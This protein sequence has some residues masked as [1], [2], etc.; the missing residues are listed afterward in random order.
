[1][2][3]SCVQRHAAL[4]LLCA[5]GLFMRFAVAQDP[6][7]TTA[8]ASQE[9]HAPTIRVT[10][11]IVVLDVTVMDKQ[12]HLVTRPLDRDDFTVLEDGVPQTIR[13]F[14][15]PTEHRM[16][17]TDV[18]I[19]HSAADLKKIGDAPVDVLV[20][21]E[22]N[23]RFEDMSFARQQM[24]KYLQTQ[25]SVLRQPTLLLIAA[26]THFVQVHDYTQDRD[27]LINVIEK[28]MPEF[29]WRMENGAAG[30]GAAERMAQ[31]MAALIQIAQATTGT[32]GRKNII[33][34]G[35]GFPSANLVGLPAD[36][37][38]VIEA[39]F[40]RVTAELLAAH[41]TVYTISPALRASYTV[42]VFGPEDMGYP[43]TLTGEDPFGTG[44]VDFIN[45]APFTGGYAFAGRNDINNLIAEA[46]GNG[47]YYYTLSYAPAN[48]SDDPLKFRKITIRMKDPSLRAI[49]R[50]GY[51]QLTDKDLNPVT[52]TETTSLKQA[53][54]NLQLDMSQALTSVITYNGLDVT[55]QKG[56]DGTYRVHVAE[57]GLGWSSPAQD[58]K[59]INEAT[60]A[61]AWFDSKGKMLGHVAR[62]ETCPRR[63]P[64]AG[65]D[66]SLPITLP[67]HTARLRLMVR[68]ARSAN[69]GT[70]DITK[71]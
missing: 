57:K 14:E 67:L 69:I 68:D 64:D 58:G 39:A 46:I 10:S 29:P 70:V 15:P 38:D 66:Y 55:A 62:E 17:Q 28:H 60:I 30:P 36:E 12:R 47:Q 50:N 51:Y 45:L 49:T 20:L 54:R 21:D 23:T 61:A 22:L 33:W 37:A 13:S 34:V 63:A 71:F 48:K 24:V 52:V 4:C 43:T 26:N 11:R 35:N 44:G 56:E 42:G 6:G 8:A 41:A 59:E 19:V 53:Q 32:P 25:P 65:A 5:L 40:R 31:V 2:S 1:M 9:Y 18:P 3:G 27:G 7:S 16:P